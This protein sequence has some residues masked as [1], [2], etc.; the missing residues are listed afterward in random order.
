MVWKEV[1]ECWLPEIS[2]TVQFNPL[3][4]ID[5]QVLRLSCSKHGL[6]LEEA[7]I[8]DPVL[9]LELCHKVFVL[10]VEHG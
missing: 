8:S 6:I 5:V 1:E 3:I 9:G 10:P 7:H 4:I 2:H